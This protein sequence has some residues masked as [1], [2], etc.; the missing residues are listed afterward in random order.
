MLTNIS[1]KEYALAI[2]ALLF[3]YYTWLLFIFYAKDILRLFKQKEAPEQGLPLNDNDEIFSVVYS[4]QDE[5]KEV[6]TSAAAKK[7]AKQE[8]ILSLKS[9]LK[10]YALAST[11]FQFAINNFIE[12]QCEK[13]CSIHLDEADLKQLWVR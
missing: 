12:R 4:L 10:K 11:P 2:T 9:V 3:L 7:H 1:W 8:I 13:N 6:I 5:V